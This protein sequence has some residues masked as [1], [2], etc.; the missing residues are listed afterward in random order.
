MTK[1]P[2]VSMLSIRTDDLNTHK[3]RLLKATFFCSERETR[4]PD[5]TIMSRTL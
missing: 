2:G 3:K 5:L 1:T 4:T